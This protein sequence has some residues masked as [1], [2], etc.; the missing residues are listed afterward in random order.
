MLIGV[1]SAMA[2]SIGSSGAKVEIVLNNNPVCATR[3]E[4]VVKGE[5][6]SGTNRPSITVKGT[7]FDDGEHTLTIAFKGKVIGEGVVSITQGSFDKVL[8]LVAPLENPIEIEVRVGEGF[9]ERIPVRLRRLYGTVVDFDGTPVSRPIINASSGMSAVGN[10]SGGFEIYLSGKQSSIGVFAEDYSKATLECWLYDVDLKE[11]TRIAVRIDKLEVYELGAW[12]A[13][14][15]VYVH[16]IPMSL[17]RVAQLMKE[18]A[19]GMALSCNRETWPHLRK[20]DVKAIIDD[21]EVPISTFNEY[22][23]FLG[24][25]DGRKCTRPGYIIGISRE[26]WKP[27]IVKIEISHRLE[28]AGTP[29]VEKGE[30]YYFG[31]VTAE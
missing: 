16:F 3:L 12:E 27:G 28:K 20:E 26:H 24:E 5:V 30:G 21:R 25:Y 1:G 13:T 17:T 8:E 31:F 9:K 2:N 7:G 23:D 11:D 22:E 19:S 14:T 10:Y 6:W 15:G 29:M 18:G 4:S